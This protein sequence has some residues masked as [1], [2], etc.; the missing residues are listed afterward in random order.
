MRIAS[1]TQFVAEIAEFVSGVTDSVGISANADASC[2]G[3]RGGC[4][5]QIVPQGRGTLQVARK[6][7]VAQSAGLGALSWG[8][9]ASKS[10]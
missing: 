7:Q 3:Q 10:R 8:Y 6:N 2:D 4:A 9:S 5:A 1:R